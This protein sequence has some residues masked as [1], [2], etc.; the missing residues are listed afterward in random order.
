MILV[1][2]QS[3]RNYESFVSN[4]YRVQL[5]Q[6][7]W[8]Q[9]E[10]SSFLIASSLIALYSSFH[11]VIWENL[12]IKIIQTISAIGPK[13]FVEKSSNNL[14]NVGD[15]VL[16]EICWWLWSNP[17]SDTLVGQTHQWPMLIFNFHAIPLRNIPLLHFV[18]MVVT[19]QMRNYYMDKL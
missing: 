3:I 1:S 16:P 9:I 17:Y 2:T 13:F 15:N 18:A 4:R 12:P 19:F 5:W 14:F 10:W 7:I 11:V 6:A 8:W